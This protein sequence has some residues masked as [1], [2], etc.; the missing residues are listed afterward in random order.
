MTRT[1]SFHHTI[2]ACGTAAFPSSLL[3]DIARFLQVEKCGIVEYSRITHPYYIDAA[4]VPEAETRLYLAGAY[5]F[6][7]FFHQW[8]HEGRSGVMTL[9]AIRNQGGSLARGA[10]D[11]ILQ[12]QP[13]TGMADE[14]A[15][16]LNKIGLATDNYFFLRDSPF[17]DAEIAAIAQAVP[18]LQALYDLNQNLILRDIGAG[19]PPHA[20]VSRADAYAVHDRQG[21]RVV[22]SPS[23]N[24]LLARADG[25]AD[26]IAEVIS[27]KQETARF[28]G[29]QVLR[30][31]LG[32]DFSPCPNGM[33]VFVSSQPVPASAPVSSSVLDDM[34]TGL[35]TEREIAIC[36]LILKGYPSISIAEKLG[37]ALG[38][39]KN[40]RKNIYRKMDIT[41]ERELFLM[42]LAHV[43]D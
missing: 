35:L 4:H 6:D 8:S 1:F 33:I 38:T 37:I 18:M 3:N 10:S 39:V 11:Y 42:L 29:Y 32:A 17:D 27:G 23:W 41:S 5:R 2:K 20:P 26:A 34:F 12:F 28:Q 15:L 16:L 9:E 40:H 21:Q 43:S 36:L 14:M 31:P 24:T 19:A 25:L 22:A 13:L 7:P 30:E